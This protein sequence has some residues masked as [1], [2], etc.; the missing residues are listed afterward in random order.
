MKVPT[1]KGS[2]RHHSSH[3][4]PLYTIGRSTGNL[5]NWQ[6]GRPDGRNWCRRPHW[7]SPLY[8]YAHDH[9][10]RSGC[11]HLAH[12]HNPAWCFPTSSSSSR[13]PECWDSSTKRNIRILLVRNRWKCR[14]SI[15]TAIHASRI[16]CKNYTP[17]CPIRRISSS[18]PFGRSGM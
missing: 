4:A 10:D 17:S 13:F 15:R 2:H 5:S 16:G 12:M 8:C 11:L 6:R 1:R 14:R 18:Q 7:R 3:P 9:F